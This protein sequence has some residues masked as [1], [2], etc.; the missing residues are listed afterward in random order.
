MKN[1]RWTF[2]LV[3]VL[4]VIGIGFYYIFMNHMPQYA[5]KGVLDFHR[6][7]WPE[8]GYIELNGE[9]EFY[10]GEFIEPGQFNE[11]SARYIKVPGI[12]SRDVEGET[13]PVKGFGTY[14]LRLVNI[15]KES[16]AALKKTSI[17]NA[18]RLYVNGELLAEDGRV[19]ETRKGSIP[20][21]SQSLFFLG[22]QKG[23]RKLSFTQPTTSMCKGASQDLCSLEIRRLFRTAMTR[24]C[25]SNFS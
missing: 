4:I 11:K 19:S 9:W 8:N 18:S 17:R 12:W 16:E 2:L 3:S 5:E 10:Y 1:I 14:R 6:V 15:P 25:F 24:I 13:Y 20:G 22:C 21:I 7:E 23:R